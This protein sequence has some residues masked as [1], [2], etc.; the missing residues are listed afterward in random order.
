MK[1]REDRRAIVAA[2]LTL[3]ALLLLP[4]APSAAQTIAKPAGVVEDWSHHHLV[5]SN[6]GTL[7]DA[8]RTGTVDK[9]YKIVNDPRYRNEQSRRMLNRARPARIPEGRV[10]KDWSEALTSGGVAANLTATIGTPSSSTIS[11][12]STLTVD[13]VTFDASPP[14]TGNGDYHL[15]Q[16][17]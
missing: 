6:P 14:D 1:P 11:G 8:V 13:G 17:Q 9:W 3:A 4:A 5:F 15:Q 2:A 16:L 12:G 10:E 7:P